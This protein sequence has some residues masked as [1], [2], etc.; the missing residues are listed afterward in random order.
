MGRAMKNLDSLLQ[1]P[2]GCG[3]QNMVLFAPNIYI[4][5]YLQSTRQ[6]TMEIQTRATGF[7]DSGEWAGSSSVRHNMLQLLSDMF[8]YSLHSPFYS[9]NMLFSL[10]DIT[11]VK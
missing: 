9:V 1:M 4:L 6:L 11:L 10:L 7:L 8:S 3:E 2:Y 5:N